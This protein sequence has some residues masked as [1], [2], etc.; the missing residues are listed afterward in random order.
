MTDRY[1]QLLQAWRREKENE[2]LQQI[3]D[4]FLTEMDNYTLILNKSILEGTSLKERITKQESDQATKMLNDLTKLRLAKI[5]KSELERLPINATHLTPKEKHL[6]ANF[7]QLLSDYT[8]RAPYQQTT[9]IPIKQEP[10]SILK[11]EQRE[12]NYMVLRFLK[13]LPAIMGTDLKAYG[14]FK[15]EDVASVP[16]ENALNLIRRGIAKE[17]KIEP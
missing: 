1:H 9:S 15:A 2:E 14:P 3:P 10:S 8:Q 13:P 17:V 12:K 11:P 16:Q 6:H 7:R 5:V 4:H